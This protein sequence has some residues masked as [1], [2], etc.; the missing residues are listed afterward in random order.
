MGPQQC[1]PFFLQKGFHMKRMEAL[2]YL[3]GALMGFF[4][5]VQLMKVVNT[6][7]VS[8]AALGAIVLNFIVLYKISKER[9]HHKLNQ[10]LDRE[11][12][13]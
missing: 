12:G 8:Y 3:S 5:G 13:K 4:V 7:M 9:K 11:L 10:K 1:G 2:K 6:D